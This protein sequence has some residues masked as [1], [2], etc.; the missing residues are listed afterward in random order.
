VKPAQAVS[1]EK[2][3]NFVVDSNISDEIDNYR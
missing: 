1:I 3:E 2:S